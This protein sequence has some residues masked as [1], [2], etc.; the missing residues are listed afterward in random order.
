MNDGKRTRLHK[1]MSSTTKIF[2]D[3]LFFVLG[4]VALFHF[5][6]VVQPL[7]L[8]LV[9]GRRRRF[10]PRGGATG[11]LVQR[12]ET[13]LF[14]EFFQGGG[15]LR[16]KKRTMSKTIHL[17]STRKRPRSSR[18]RARVETEIAKRQK[19]FSY[20]SGESDKSDA[21]FFS[22]KRNRCDL[23]PLCSRAVSFP[24]FL[25]H[26][27]RATIFP[28]S[29]VLTLLGDPSTDNRRNAPD[30]SV[31]KDS[32]WCVL[33]PVRTW[34]RTSSSWDD[35]SNVFFCAAAPLR[36]VGGIADRKKVVQR[37]LNVRRFSFARVALPSSGGTTPGCFCVRQR[38][39]ERFDSVVRHFVLCPSFFGRFWRFFPLFWGDL[40]SFSALFSLGFFSWFLCRGFCGSTNF[41]KK[42][43]IKT[44]F[45][46]R[47]FFL[48]CA[49]AEKLFFERGEELDQTSN[50]FFLFLSGNKSA[51]KARKNNVQFMRRPFC[52]RLAKE[53]PHQSKVPDDT[54]RQKRE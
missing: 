38:V 11:E 43:K 50:T 22:G 2:F 8:L 3:V 35:G 37:Y 23:C 26:Q 19:I 29:D 41:L 28:K 10:T 47:F 54:R 33:L 34:Q 36:R 18:R 9:F 7:L 1:P 48:L 30:N 15:D 16:Q 21:L 14:S 31:S 13:P 53:N 46:G 12:G 32:D 40:T 20:R 44:T 45:I 5:F 52:R 4:V 27:S 24:R 51:R 39:A 49:A 42:S 17:N 6:L 25:R